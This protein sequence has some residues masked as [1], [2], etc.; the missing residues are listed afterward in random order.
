MAQML[1]GCTRP[2][3]FAA[4]AAPP[5][6]DSSLVAQE[7]DHRL[8]LMFQVCCSFIDQ[9]LAQVDHNGANEG[10]CI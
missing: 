9:S 4:A 3:A 10:C 5:L 7:L 2:G 8:Q 1:R 6:E